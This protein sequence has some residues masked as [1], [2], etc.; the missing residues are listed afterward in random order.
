MMNEQKT[1]AL[2]A[3]P[4]LLELPSERMIDAM[5]A[6][7]DAGFVVRQVKGL[8]NRYRIDDEDDHDLPR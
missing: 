2:P 6:L 1:I 3:S 8:E 7:Q 4:F 5:N